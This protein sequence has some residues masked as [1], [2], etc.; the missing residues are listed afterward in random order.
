MLRKLKGL[1]EGKKLRGAN[2]TSYERD[3]CASNQSAL[4]ALD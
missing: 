2:A 3:I 4:V 1:L